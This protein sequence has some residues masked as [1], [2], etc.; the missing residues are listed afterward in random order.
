[1]SSQRREFIRNASMS[2]GGLLL[3]NAVKAMQIEPPTVAL[4]QVKNGSPGQMARKAVELLGGMSQFVKKGQTVLLKPNMSWDR[5]PEQAVNTNPEVVAEVIKMCL[6]AGASRVVVLDRTLDRAD[7]CYRNSGIAKAASAAGGDVQYVQDKLF[8]PVQIK[9]GA[10]LR[11]WTFYREALEADVLINVPILKRHVITSVTMGF[12]NMMGLVGG[13]RN[14][15]HNLFDKTIV[16]I[17]TVLRPRLTILDAYRALLQN[18]P[19]GGSLA[20]VYKM[21]TLVAGTDPVLVDSAGAK[22]LGMSSR[23]VAYLAFAEKAGLGSADL[24][25]HKPV[26]Y[27][28]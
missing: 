24:S 18:G 16:D 5:P 7:N 21:K 3:A 19:G 2:A 22:L 4:A 27:S 25:T 14:R 1:M 20:G 6:E 10:V 9:N 8:V 28:F 15:F 11:E 26:E 12:K 17:N 23:N 13:D